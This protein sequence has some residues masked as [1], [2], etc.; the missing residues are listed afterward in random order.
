MVCYPVIINNDLLNM[1][2]VL[3]KAYTVIKSIVAGRF[4]FNQCIVQGIF[5]LVLFLIIL[6]TYFAMYSI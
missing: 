1:R 5:I 3:G 4:Q 6:G 2:V